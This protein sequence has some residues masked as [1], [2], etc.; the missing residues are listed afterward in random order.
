MFVGGLVLSMDY[1]LAP[2]TRPV[3]V[4][5]KEYVNGVSH[6]GLIFGHLL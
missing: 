1:L 3:G 5:L 4:A 2:S 6:V